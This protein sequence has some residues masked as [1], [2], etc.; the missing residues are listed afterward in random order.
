M[1]PAV[2]QLSFDPY[3]RFAGQAVRWEALALAAA[4][5][6]ALVVTA[7]VAGRRPRPSTAGQPGGRPAS[8]DDLLFIVLGIIPGAVIG[9]RLTYL[10]VHLDYYQANPTLAID[11]SSGGLA[12]SGAVVLG[13][14]T[15]IYVAGLLEAP[16]GRWLDIAAVGLLLGLG[17]GELGQVLG[18]SGQ[19]VVSGAD[20]ATAYV[21]VGP[22]GVLG[23]DLPALPA[24]VFEAIG[25]AI[26]LVLVLG[27]G[28][29]G[30]FQRA[31]GRRFIVA[32]GGWAV[33][34]FVVATW[35][36]DAAVLGSLK[37]EQLIDIGILLI[38]LAGLVVVRTRPATIEATMPSAP[39]PA[40]SPGVAR[41]AS[42]RGDAP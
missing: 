18:G 27:A 34:R 21:G 13:T 2:I 22:W 24:Q 14:L 9:G 26:L 33:V 37:V 3:L 16:I 30:P 1:Q 23:A 31:N 40:A 28:R 39:A 7:L 42:P 36:R 25:D 4:V 12:L 11:P 41:S 10:L 20:W 29:F 15:G 38:A 8:R 5:F 32:L 6:I 19:G 35:W 17:L